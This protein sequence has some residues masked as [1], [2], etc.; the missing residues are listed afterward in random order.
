MDRAKK[1]TNGGYGLLLDFYNIFFH[2]NMLLY[3][4][5]LYIFILCE[6]YMILYIKE[7]N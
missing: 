1:E 4:L 7:K 2:I 3:F 6:L 5:S